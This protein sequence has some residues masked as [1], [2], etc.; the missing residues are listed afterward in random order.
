M[1]V[2]R[3]GEPP[4]TSFADAAGKDFEGMPGVSVTNA[5]EIWNQENPDQTI[6]IS[7][8]ESDTAVK[9]QRIEDGSADLGIIDIA[10]YNA[11]QDEY[12]YALQAAVIPEEEVEMIADNSYAYYILPMDQSGLRDELNEVL[13]E[14]QEDGTLTE[15]S[16]KWFGQDTAPEADKFKETIN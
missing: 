11:Y 5:V 7:Y 1:F 4:V 15:L 14:M 16:T 6:N 13:K 2:T 8:S 3:E 12:D 9:L 10:M